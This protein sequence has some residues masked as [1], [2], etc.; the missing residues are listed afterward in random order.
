MLYVYMNYCSNLLM[1][2]KLCV[3]INKKVPF[4]HWTKVET[5]EDMIHMY[6]N[7]VICWRLG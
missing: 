4:I 6:T 5:L 7:P 3:P 1:M 2:W